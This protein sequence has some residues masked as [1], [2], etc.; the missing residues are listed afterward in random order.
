MTKSRR[1]AI[2]FAGGVGSRLH[3]S[4]IPKQF[5]LLSGKP[6]IIHTIELFEQHESV[7]DII[8][9]CLESWI[10]EL[11]KMLREYGIQKV[12][13]VVSGG[14]NTQ[15]SIYNGLCEAEK[16]TKEENAVVLIHDGVRPLICAQ[17][18]SDNIE[19]VVKHGS[20]I[21]CALPTETIVVNE[22]EGI[23]VPSRSSLLVARAPQSFWLKDIIETHRQAIADGNMHFID[24]CEMMHH[25]GHSLNMV[26]G[27]SENL[28][29]TTIAD[30]YMCEAL[31]KWRHSN[32]Q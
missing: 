29:I 10:E 23:E 8:V 27:P 4:D 5:M 14:R 2:I 17:T 3:P 12:R 1:V 13:N 21:T 32:E 16:L 26:L 22:T 6:V 31:M 20:C 18:I 7:T 19:S 25:Y 24:C 9:V 30:F 15:E 11:K 28:K